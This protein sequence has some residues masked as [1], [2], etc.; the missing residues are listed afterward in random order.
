M[1]FI[2]WKQNK[3]Q[4]KIKQAQHKN[5]PKTKPPPKKKQKGRHIIHE[6]NNNNNHNNRRN[7][8]TTRTEGNLG[9]KKRMLGKFVWKKQANMTKGK[10]NKKYRRNPP[11]NKK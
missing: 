10:G 3:K 2:V 5:I 11:Q 9:F 6:K 8:E 4:N 1:F 7:E